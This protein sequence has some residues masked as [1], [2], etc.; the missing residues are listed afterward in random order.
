MTSYE[1]YDKE[2]KVLK[3]YYDE[4][5]INPRQDCNLGTMICWHRSYDLGDKHDYC[6]PNEFRAEINEKNAI[7]LPLYLYDHSGLAMST[8][9]FSCP[10]DSGQVGWIYVS[11]EK[12]R[13]EF[14]VKK[15][16]RKIQEQ[17]ERILKSEVE[18]QQQYLNGEIFGYILEDTEG[19]ELDSCWGFYGCNF[20][21]N[22]MADY[23][24]Q[25]WF[26]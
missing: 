2:D 3:I 13:E 15:I 21:E 18:V 10:W 4:D 11:K 14:R 1:T 16:T 9:P 17:V 5:A 26:N 22:G 24:G 7:I 20:K 19:N 8:A 23:V 6:S 25:E 12:V